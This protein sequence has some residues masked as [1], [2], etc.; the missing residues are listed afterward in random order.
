MQHE[1]YA[2]RDRAYGIHPITGGTKWDDDG[3]KFG[4]NRVK[5]L[6]SKDPPTV[7]VVFSQNSVRQIKKIPLQRGIFIGRG[8]VW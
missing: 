5:D 2:V 1:Q 7:F 3:T 8:R 6:P 4:K